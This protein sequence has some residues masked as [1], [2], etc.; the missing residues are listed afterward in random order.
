MVKTPKSNTAQTSS[1][2]RPTRT[3]APVSFANESNSEDTRWEGPDTVT[4]EREDVEYESDDG[5][6]LG[7]FMQELQKRQAKK[8]TLL[9]T[10]FDNQKKATYDSARKQAKE[11][12]QEGLGYLEDLRVMLLELKKDE[13]P[14]KKYSH[15]VDPLWKNRE[16]SLASLYDLYPSVVDDLFVRRA[17][18]ID[19]A[20]G[21][22][23]INPSKREKALRSFLENARRE[24]DRSRQKE[25]EATDASKLI[26]HYKALL[27]G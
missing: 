18:V 4:R 15:E 23:R 11:T 26:K 21:M 3:S 25:I 9:S 19:D 1:A 17:Q 22:I 7:K 24:V 27:F 13:I 5:L 6:E 8:T 14:F 10:A 16:T 2:K 20:S 12:S